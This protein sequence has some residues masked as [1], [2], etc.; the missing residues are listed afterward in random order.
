MIQFMKSE[1]WSNRMPEFIEY[2]QLMDEIR[3]TDFSKTFPE[4]R[5]LLDYA[6]VSTPSLAGGDH[7]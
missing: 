4:M 2:I 7:V 5:E 6:Q 3:G 1:D